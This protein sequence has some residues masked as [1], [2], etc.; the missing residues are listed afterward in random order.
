VKNAGLGRFALVAALVLGACGGGG[1]GSD[2]GD[3]GPDGGGGSTAGGGGSTA[4]STGAAGSSPDATGAAGTGSDGGVDASDAPM[5]DA[6]SDPHP[7][8]DAPPD[9]ATDA[10]VASGSWADLYVC[11]TLGWGSKPSAAAF[12]PGGASVAIA[13]TGVKVFDVATGALT[14]T[15]GGIVGDAASV[16]VSA[17]GTRLAASV[18]S[19]DIRLSG[20]RV[21]V[22][23][24]SDGA[25]FW[26]RPGPK[27][28]L[29]VAFSPDGALL[30]MGDVEN[31]VILANAATGAT[32]RTYTEH[33]HWVGGVAFSPDGALIAST[34]DTAVVKIW[35]TA[36]LATQ[37]TLTGPAGLVRY[38]ATFSADG[39]QIYSSALRGKYKVSDGTSVGA[40]ASSGDAIFAPDGLSF[41]A[42]PTLYRASDGVA[43]R[44]VNPT[45]SGLAYKPD[46]SSVLVSA[47]PSNEPSKPY[48]FGVLDGAK[49]ATFTGD[50]L[51]IAAPAI[52]V[53]GKRAFVG[54][55]MYDLTTGLMLYETPFVTTDGA[56]AVFSP[57]GSLVAAA[58]GNGTL[59]LMKVSDGKLEKSIT[60]HASSIGTI[61]FSP[62]GDRIATGSADHLVKVWN[63]NGLGAIRT[64]GGIEGHTGEVSALAWSPDGGLL[65]SSGGGGTLVW[66]V[67]DGQIRKT[68][69]FGRPA[70]TSDG[71]ALRLLGGA[72]I[73]KVDLVGGAP[74]AVL[75]IPAS[76][77][78]SIWGRNLAPAADF[79][80]AKSLGGLDVELWSLLDGRS[81]T[82][83]GVPLGADWAFF[84]PDRLVLAQPNPAIAKIATW[85][86]GPALPPV[87]VPP[88]TGGPIATVCG[89]TRAFTGDF[90]GDD[91]DDCVY[92]PN[93][94]KT[95]QFHKGLAGG[96]AR[97]NP[98]TATG[99]GFCLPTSYRDVAVVDANGDGRDDLV[100]IYLN[101]DS[102]KPTAAQIV[103]GR[104]DGLFRCPSSLAFETN[105]A[106][107]VANG[108]KPLVAN[109]TGDG[110]GDV[111]L[112]GFTVPSYANSNILQLTVLDGERTSP[113]LKA[114]VTDTTFI[115][116]ATGS[117]TSV[118]VSDVNIDGKLDVVTNVF[119]RYLNGTGPGAMTLTW[120][121]KGDGTFSQ[122]PPP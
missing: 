26:T 51:E 90:D 67:A 122:T 119:V 28:V 1:G 117:V 111:L 21:V 72:V 62:N 98:I 71:T 25:I 100:S 57:D 97:N 29:S 16:A 77:S 6:P 109:F 78:G 89:T 4:G 70:F 107:F 44:T 102:V 48:L 114:I 15:Y 82:T 99:L 86:K 24:V 52:S 113:G 32:V 96:L 22:W 106:T 64:L 87:V 41:Y 37:R 49:G 53:D 61:A 79:V 116:G 18:A 105:I 54:H 27:G 39:T 17:D 121:G 50:P 65:A 34:D 92:W 36:D 60:A 68:L 80:A 120:Y 85:C 59:N 35:K 95:L 75:D 19:S 104:E 55:R 43:L 84:A 40:A 47:T 45:G 11:G 83:L 103:L 9:V 115:V 93:N 73:E 56:S 63:T 94:T 81:V 10:P 101:G 33:A 20:P 30:A 38:D 31:K 3:G 69:P 2:A 91:L 112:V 7:V 5:G 13:G 110:S 23:R 46:S 14:R 108:T 74:I 66:S 88:D 58:S 118:S 76:G 12:F 42:S 8:T